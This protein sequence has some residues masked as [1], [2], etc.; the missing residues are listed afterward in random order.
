MNRN[1]PLKDRRSN[2]GAIPRK[3]KHVVSIANRRLGTQSRVAGTELFGLL[4]E[5]DTVTPGHGFTYQFLA[6]TN[7]QNDFVHPGRLRGIN[8]PIENGATGHQVHHLG[9]IGV[10]PRAL[11]GGK[12]DRSRNTIGGAGSMRC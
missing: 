3:N 6:I 5:R 11:A 7:N 4:S 8:D 2:K 9:E 1:Q 12:D 10:H